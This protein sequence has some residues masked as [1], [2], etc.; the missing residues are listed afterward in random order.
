MRKEHAL[1]EDTNGAATHRG[2]ASFEGEPTGPEDAPADRPP[3]ASSL[4]W[5][6]ART[7]YRSRRLILGATF[8]VA[9]LA[10]II[11]LLLPKWYAGTARVLLPESGGGGIGALIGD[12]SPIGASLFGGGAG[13]YNRYLALLT[14]RS[15]LEETVERFDLI[16]VYD[17]GDAEA[18]TE[19]AVEQLAGN[20]EFEVDLQYEFLE[21]TAFDRDRERAAAL[22]NFLVSELNRRSQALASQNAALYRRYVEERYAEAEA[23][24]DSLR[25][26]MQAFQETHGVVELPTMTQAFLETA[27]AQRAQLAELEIQ[28]E[29]LRAQYGED[30]PQVQAARDA[31]TAGRRAERNLLGGGEAMMP[32]P[33][34]DLPA[35]ASEYARLYQALL[36][37][38]EILETTRPLLEQ[39]RFEEQRERTAVQVVDQAVPPSRKA[40]PKRSVLVIVTTLSGFLLVVLF[41]LAR[42]WLWRN[43]RRIARELEAG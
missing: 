23:E 5:P 41:V 7:L 18:P 13:D 8:V 9:V 20:V 35:L 17:L 33:L 38:A 4:L 25:G 21:I 31:V 10:V 32:V 43:R 1:E 19:E 26:E 11:S 39:A 24:L 14:S 3:E 37:Q 40:K 34:R 36:I 16:A 2:D 12:L 27:A 28:Y 6:V 30:N 22:T 15:L 42:D 29:A